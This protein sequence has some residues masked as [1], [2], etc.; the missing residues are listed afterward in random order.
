[1]IVNYRSWQK[2]GA[3]AHR[4]VGVSEVRKLFKCAHFGGYTGNMM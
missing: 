4:C 3:G 1:M 2:G